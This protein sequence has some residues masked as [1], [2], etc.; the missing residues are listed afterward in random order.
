MRPRLAML[1]TFV[2]ATALASAAHGAPYPGPGL[3]DPCIPDPSIPSTPLRVE[4]TSPP[5]GSFH[6]L[7]IKGNEVAVTGQ[8][9]RP[10]HHP[11]TVEVNGKPVD[12][13]SG[14][15]FATQVSFD[16]NPGPAVV[17]PPV[18]TILPIVAEVR[19]SCTEPLQNPAR[20]PVLR[21]RVTIVHGKGVS[22]QER[23]FNALRIRVMKSLFD[24]ALESAQQGMPTSIEEVIDEQDVDGDEQ[25]H[26]TGLV[27]VDQFV[28]RDL[29]FHDGYAELLLD[30]A[31][32]VQVHVDYVGEMPFFETDVEGVC[33]LTASAPVYGHFRFQL[34]DD[35]S[36]SINV[37]GY[38]SPNAPDLVEIEVGPVS[39]SYGCDHG[40][41][42]EMLAEKWA[43]KKAHLANTIE[44]KIE[45]ASGPQDGNVFAAIE[46]ALKDVRLESAIAGALAPI[47]ADVDTEIAY[48]I[49]PDGLDIWV[50][51]GLGEPS[52]PAY[53][54]GKDRFLPSYFAPWQMQHLHPALPCDDDG[55]QTTTPHTGEGYDVA[56]SAS[57]Y[58]L[59]W[60][61]RT[62]AARGALDATLFSLQSPFD[63]SQQFPLKAGLLSFLLLPGLAEAPPAT[64]LALEVEAVAAPF[65]TGR[66]DAPMRPLSIDDSLAGTFAGSLPSSGDRDAPL[67]TP[68]PN[69]QTDQP[70]PRTH[71]PAPTGSL[72]LDP[73]VLSQIQPPLSVPEYEL[74]IPDLRLR[75]VDVGFIDGFC[76][77]ED[78]VYLELAVA[79]RLG[80]SLGREGSALNVAV[81][82][83]QTED[84]SVE[85]VRAPCGL[86]PAMFEDPTYLGGVYLPALIAD[87]IASAVESVEL[88]GPLPIAVELGDAPKP[89][90]DLD[91][92][93]APDELRPFV[94]YLGPPS[95]SLLSS[96]AST[97]IGFLGT[98][99]S[100]Q[101]SIDP[102]IPGPVASRIGAD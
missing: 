63:P 36:G 87:Q 84:V 81:Y 20:T 102:A 7:L 23:E 50:D 9:H 69:D 78:G 8:V 25:S 48:Q 28:L 26:T 16:W 38:V 60:Y 57:P 52:D 99:E 14:G 70:A 51:L 73:G 54:L 101:R 37:L 83:P 94:L 64:E 34:F 10:P 95:L 1:S 67:P 46:I 97:E 91:L 66:R 62:L 22:V 93:G 6:D 39:D 30:F 35:P 89:L 100:T 76:Q 86:Y 75:V 40:P 98:Q 17:V 59:N 55:C 85:V 82:P 12:I 13:T 24:A 33:D 3:H 19:D 43:V 90:L 4:I 53:Q 61:L 45:N 65:L 88:P 21:D 92:P 79:A 47:G 2:L 42:E 15:S 11:V 74:W 80:L 71:Q 49:D 77:A 5:Q 27:R 31:L 68:D 41:A 44:A 32:G 56:M 18:G 58:L 72:V 96:P 29:V